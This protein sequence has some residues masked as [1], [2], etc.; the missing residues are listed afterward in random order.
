MIEN[1]LVAKF[2][3]L[4]KPMHLKMQDII[5]GFN[6]EYLAQKVQRMQMASALTNQLYRQAEAS[7]F[8]F[9]TVAV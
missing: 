5:T 7:I 8:F 6:E 3:E 1:L 4:I 9:P 2:T